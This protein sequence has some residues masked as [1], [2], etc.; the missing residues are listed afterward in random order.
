MR[1][2]GGLILWDGLKEIQCGEVN[3]YFMID[4]YELDLIC[5]K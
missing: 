1:T 3:G 5:L 2:F 4:N